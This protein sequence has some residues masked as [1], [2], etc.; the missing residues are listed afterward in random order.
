M[1]GL[2]TAFG[3][4][5]MTNSIAEIENTDSL[6]VIGSNTTENHPIIALRM[7]KA[8]RNGAK[9]IVADPRRIPLVKFAH[10]WLRHRPGTDV[11]L[12]NTMMHVI[13][14]EKLHNDT[15]IRERTEGFKELK[16]SLKKFTP[17]YGAK[18]TGVPKGDIIQAARIYAEAD[19]AGIYYTMGITQHSMGTN[20][21]FSLANLAALTGN[22]GRESTGVNPLRGQNNVQGCCDMGCSPNVLPGYQNVTDLAVRSRFEDV[23]GATIPDK[24]GLTATEMTGAMIDG[25]LKC[26][27]VMGENPALS[28]PNMTHTIKAFKNLDFLVVQDIFLTETAELADVVLPAASFAEKEGTF[29]NTERR[30]QRVRKAISSPGE[31]KDDL[32]IISMLSSSLGYNHVL[33]SIKALGFQV[34]KP[35]KENGVPIITP[36][37]LF[38]EACL[39]WPAMAGMTYQRL[40]DRGKQWPC[41][42]RD[43]PGTTYLF[44]D[45]FPRGKAAFT[46]VPYLE[47]KELPD[48]E[49]PFLLTTGRIL[50]QYHTG[51]MTRRS[52]ALE[53]VAPEPFIEINS[54]DALKMKVES[55]TFMTATSRRG[56]IRLKARVSDIV[57]PGVVFIPFHYKEAAANLLT[58]DALDP[59]CKIAEAKVCAVRLKKAPERRER[60]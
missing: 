39:L 45:G 34:E 60:G 18:I 2:A 38:Q 15:F 33:E 8:V 47:S 52:K 1:A 30:V 14:K 21:V 50:F 24:V 48:K 54:E 37:D 27:Y 35:E 56:S 43:R 55:G 12:I 22:L 10:L 13:L 51:T 7:K 40:K 25:R 32:T 31:A 49:Y 11:A 46:P 57:G 28:D 58:N 6:F 59:I 19:K 42:R 16:A 20:N 5:A 23:W 9:L 36:E 44:K 17:A 41:T 3:S 29:T 26:L 4:G 53:S